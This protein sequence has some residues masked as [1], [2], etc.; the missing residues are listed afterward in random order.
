MSHPVSEKYA[1]AL[2]EATIDD[3]HS[4]D[5]VFQNLVMVKELVWDHEDVRSFMLHPNIDKAEKN[6]FF[7]QNLKKS[8]I[9]RRSDWLL[10]SFNQSSPLTA[11][12]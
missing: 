6:I 4:L 5:A 7:S 8:G 1:R 9:F 2:L 11:V 12:V 10:S 3:K